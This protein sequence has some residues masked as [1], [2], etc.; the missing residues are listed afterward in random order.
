MTVMYAATL[1]SVIHK[2]AVFPA[3]AGHGTDGEV[4]R[5]EVCLVEA[6]A[7]SERPR[8]GTVRSLQLHKVRMLYIARLY[9]TFTRRVNQTLAYLPSILACAKRTLGLNLGKVYEL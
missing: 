1:E 4:E 2:L 3:G 6:I 5:T 9:G 8:P 7:V